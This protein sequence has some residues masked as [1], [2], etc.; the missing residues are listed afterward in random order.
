MSI[1]RRLLSIGGGQVRPFKF[2]IQTTS[3]NTQFE[4]PIT[5]PGGNQPNLKVS[6]VD[7][8]LAQ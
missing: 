3:A 7:F 6:W 4:L 1:A 5:A 2:T 8:H